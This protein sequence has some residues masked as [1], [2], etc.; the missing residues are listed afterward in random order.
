[1]QLGV[2]NGHM[3]FQDYQTAKEAGE[4]LGITANQVGRLAKQERF[5]SQNAQPGAMKVAGAWF[6][7]KDST[8]R[9]VYSGLSTKT[10]LGKPPRWA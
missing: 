1:M 2:Y 8:P 9:P 6:V 5:P 4:R 7:H 3:N 10:T